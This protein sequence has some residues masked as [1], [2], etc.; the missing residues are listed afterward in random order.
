MNRVRALVELSAVAFLAGAIVLL[1][2]PCGVLGPPGQQ[3]SAA[4]RPAVRHHQRVHQHVPIPVKRPVRVEDDQQQVLHDSIAESDRL[5]SELEGIRESAVI[6]G[7]DRAEQTLAAA[8][9]Y[10][11]LSGRLLASFKCGAPKP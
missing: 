9:K 1:G 10:L 5:A 2:V 8:A 3:A 7:D 4:A 11:R 6:F